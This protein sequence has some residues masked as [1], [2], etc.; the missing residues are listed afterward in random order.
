MTDFII[1]SPY[2]ELDVKNTYCP[3]RAFDKPDYYCRLKGISCEYGLFSINMVPA[4][5]PLLEHS[6]GITIKLLHS[7]QMG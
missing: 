7:I 3:F 5:C 2:Y 1:T 6:E 4:K